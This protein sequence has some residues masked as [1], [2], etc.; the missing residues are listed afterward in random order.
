MTINTT[1]F[2]LREQAY[3]TAMSFFVHSTPATPPKTPT[4]RKVALLIAAIYIVMALAQLFSFTRFSSVIYNMW[5]P[6]IDSVA[7]SLLAALVVMAEVFMVPFLLGMRLSPAM[8]VLSMGLGWLVTIWWIVTLVWQ[9]VT[10]SAPETS[11]LLGAT[12]AVPA[13]WWSALFMLGIA[14]LVAWVSWGQWP[15]ARRK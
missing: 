3:T 5:L 8:R 13:G 1:L 12:V 6:A 15:V 10:G 7:A 4:T 2:S 14:V 9:N 11:G